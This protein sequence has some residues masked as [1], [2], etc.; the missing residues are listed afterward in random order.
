MSE[1]ALTNEAFH[2]GRYLLNVTGTKVGADYAADYMMTVVDY[3][4]AAAGA[5]SDDGSEPG[6]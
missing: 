4:D 5:K 1:D 6:L 3:L 2:V